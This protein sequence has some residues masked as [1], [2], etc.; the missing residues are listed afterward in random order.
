MLS[1]MHTIHR[2]DQA[3]LLM[4][5]KGHH[6]VT[7]HFFTLITDTFF[8]IPLYIF[9]L[10]FIRNTLGWYGVVLFILTIVLSD[11]SSAT[12]LKPFFARYRPCYVIPQVHL[13]GT[14]QGLYGFPSAHASNTYA[15]AMLFWRIFKTKYKYSGLFFI[16]AT[17]VSYGRIYGG[18]HYPLDICAGAMVGC[19]IGLLMD[20]LYSKSKP[21][22][23]N[24][25]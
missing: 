13:V 23:S 16:W 3:L 12:W 18:V 1:M 8:W 19:C 17:I 15:F 10:F 11:Q 25:N 20:Q 7:D 6:P 24:K 22:H 2:L 14:H 21:L 4:L 9:L 5:N